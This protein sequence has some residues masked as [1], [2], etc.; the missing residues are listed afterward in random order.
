MKA[1]VD[2][3]S[4]MIQMPD[5]DLDITNIIQADE[6][7]ALAT[8]ALGLNSVFGR[9]YRALKDILINTNPATPPFPSLCLCC[10]GCSVTTRVLSTVH[11]HSVVKSTLEN[12]LKCWDLLLIWK[13]VL[14]TQMKFS[15]QMMYPI[16]GE[17][18][19]HIF[20]LARSIML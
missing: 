16:E 2:G 4:K 5:V 9:D 17:G 12:L 10:T 18:N 19:M 20:C 8:N 14:K 13:N 6:P 3:L 7:T 11:I 15:I 1:V